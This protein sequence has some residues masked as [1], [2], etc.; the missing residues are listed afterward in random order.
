M[1]F[2]S[3]LRKT[4]GNYLIVFFHPMTA[5]QFN[6]KEIN[7]SLLSKATQRWINRRLNNSDDKKIILRSGGTLQN[8]T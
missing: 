4:L 1:L 2:I 8:I 6:S 7:P 3:L 5:H